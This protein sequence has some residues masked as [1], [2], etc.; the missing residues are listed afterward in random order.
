MESQVT[1]LIDDFVKKAKIEDEQY[2]V[3]QKERRAKRVLENEERK[4]ERGDRAYISEDTE[5]SD[6]WDT[7]EVKLREKL[8]TNAPSRMTYDKLVEGLK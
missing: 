7:K 4:K 8:A 6:D 2:K 3:K 5:E 1:Q